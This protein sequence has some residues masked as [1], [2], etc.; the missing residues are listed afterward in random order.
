MN[1]EHVLNK[2]NVMLR[3]GWKHVQLFRVVLVM[4]VAGNLDK[5]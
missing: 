3:T 2:T 5:P 1:Q 4:S